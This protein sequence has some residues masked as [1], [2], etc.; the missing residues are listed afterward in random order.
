[1]KKKTG[2]SDKGVKDLTSGD[3]ELKEFMKE[4]TQ[5]SQKKRDDFDPFETDYIK[6]SCKI[7]IDKTSL[8]INNF[9]IDWKNGVKFSVGATFLQIGSDGLTIGSNIADT[10]SSINF[11]PNGL[12]F[13]HGRYD[14]NFGSQGV[15]IHERRIGVADVDKLELGESLAIRT[16][17]HELSL[18]DSGFTLK[19]GDDIIKLGYTIV[20]EVDGVEKT[21]KVIGRK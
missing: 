18:D 20:C 9:G 4:C 19:F 2:L 16:P 21:L 11:G 15:T 8:Y 5:K 6:H 13:N 14:M 12:T 7:T 3:S 17:G 10:E 1:M